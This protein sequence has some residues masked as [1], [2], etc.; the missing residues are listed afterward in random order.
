ML[1]TVSKM[2]LCLTATHNNMIIEFFLY[3]VP[4]YLSLM[5]LEFIY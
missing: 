1:I 4:G 5:S 3:A 2:L